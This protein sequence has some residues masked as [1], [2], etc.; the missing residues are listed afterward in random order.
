VKR[1][2]TSNPNII[3]WNRGG[4]I[5]AFFGLPFLIAGLFIMSVPF[6]GIEV[7]GNMPEW[8]LIPFGGIFALVGA[9]LVFGRMGTILNRSERKLI[10]WWGLLIPFSSKERKLYD[11]EKVTLTR[12][13]RQSDKSSYT[14]Y[15]ISLSGKGKPAKILAHLLQGWEAEL[16]HQVLHQHGDNM[17]LLQHDGWGM[18]TYVN[19][20]DIEALI[21]DRTGLIMP[22][23]YK[24]MKPPQIN[25]LLC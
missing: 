19:P 14:V 9:G 13:V 23:K 2:K 24:Q 18:E 3:G 8:G 5:L 16:L 1:T 25:N 7:E 17:I 10:T 11:F 4:G 15:P 21:Q 6:S 22:I 20:D 12:E